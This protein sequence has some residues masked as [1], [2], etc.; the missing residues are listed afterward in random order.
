VDC[1][2]TQDLRQSTELI[3]GKTLNQGWRSVHASKTTGLIE[4]EPAREDFSGEGCL[5]TQLGSLPHP[6]PVRANLGSP[7]QL[8]F[9]E[10]LVEGL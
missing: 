2:T 4:A 10:R 6:T 3:L 5:L 9:A 1:L 7:L 8:F